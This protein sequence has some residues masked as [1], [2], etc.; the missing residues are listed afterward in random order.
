MEAI[1]DNI[2]AGVKAGL[3]KARKA[4]TVEPFVG[5]DFR[6]LEIGE[7]IQNGDIFV[8]DGAVHPATDIGTGV[9]SDNH[10][11]HYRAVANGKDETHDEAQR[12]L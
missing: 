2:D 6:P 9:M 3:E 4:N 7:K 12:K 10:F 11:P 1:L 8:S 5:N